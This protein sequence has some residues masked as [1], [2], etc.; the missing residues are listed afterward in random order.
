[1]RLHELHITAFGPFAETV[2]VDFDELS[3]AGLFLLSGPTG[4]GKTSVLDAVCFALYGDVPGDRNHAKRFRCDTAEPTLA[5]RV[6][7][8]ATLAGRPFRLSRS[9]AWDRPKKR[10]TGT[11][12]ENAKVLVEERIS[13]EWVLLTGRIDEAGQLVTDLLGMTMPQFCQVAMLPQGRFQAFLRAKSEDRHTLLQQL[14]STQR[15]EDIEK[16]LRERTRRLHRESR[17]HL[18]GVSRTVSRLLEA[19]G[20][21]LPEDWPEDSASDPTPVAASGQL[22]AWVAELVASSGTT[23]T[24]ARER[25]ATATAAA[26]TALRRRDEARRLLDLRRRHASAAAALAKLDSRAETHREHIT[27]LEV[28][29]RAAPF[30]PLHEYARTRATQR[31]RA[32]S[33]AAEASLAAL[34]LLEEDALFD[35]GDQAPADHGLHHLDDERLDSALAE[36]RDAR[37]RAASLQ[38]REEELT[39]IDS[40]IAADAEAVNALEEQVASRRARIDELPGQIEALPQRLEAARK[41]ADDAQSL[42]EVIKT[43]DTRLEAHAHLSKLRDEADLA[44]RD[45]RERV[46]ACQSLKETWLELREA[47]LQGMAAEIAVDLAVGASCPVCGSAEHPHKAEPA[48]GSTS[49]AEEKQV[50]SDLDTAEATRLALDLKVRELSVRLAV[51][52]KDAGE[53]GPD[54]LAAERERLAAEHTGAKAAA[55]GLAEIEPT[56][57]RATQSLKRAHGE[58]TERSTELA[59]LRT[60]LAADGSTA[61]G[62]RRELD[63]L[64]SGSGHDSVESLRDGLDRT[65]HT[66]AEASRLRATWHAA[67]TAVLDADQALAD[68]IDEHGFSDV[69]GALGSSLPQA[70]VDRLAE[71]VRTH[72]DRVTTTRATLEDPDVLAAAEAEIPDIAEVESDVARLADAADAARAHTRLAAQ[73]ATRLTRLAAELDA[74]LSGWAPVRE[75]HATAAELTAFVEGKGQD[76]ELRMRLSAYVLAWRLTQVVAAANERLLQMSDQRYTLEHTGRRGA[77]ETRGGLSLLIRDEWSGDT[78]DPATLSG[79]ETFVVS[80]ALAL[81]LADVVTREAGGADLDTLFVDEGFG[82]LDA[83]TLDDVMGTLDTL[84]DGGRVVGVVSHVAEMRSRIPMQ[85]AVTKDRSGSTVSIA[86]VTA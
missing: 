42:A 7:L 84:R 81:G 76:N 85:L 63:A 50:R 31:D 86:R 78:R 16:W 9:P 60:R 12:T 70:E 4:A 66:Y 67:E 80:L 11:T 24:E 54:Q 20:E 34:G 46:D 10:G 38:P 35:W 59:S 13:G 36:V 73:R 64:L 26:D 55:K 58:L 48:P 62:I 47:R 79:G 30:R 44:D 56:L 23:A 32:A 53:A 25:S 65:A 15:F 18:Q 41:A 74:A 33:A 71:L 17:D 5:P 21:P 43:L 51:L 49:P 2:R 40:R 28:A 22:A 77:G 29:R 52:E 14:F 83:E 19:S 61:K 82:A 27:R 75:S 8:E 3:G 69:E 37:A 57:A 6:V 72:E 39:A 45:L 68:W 1:M